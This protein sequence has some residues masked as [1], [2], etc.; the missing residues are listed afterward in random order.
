MPPGPADPLAPFHAPVRRWFLAHVGDPTAAQRH[1]WPAIA[2]GAST[3]IQAPTGSGKTLAAFLWALN[4]LAFGDGGSGCRVVYVSPLKALAVDVERNLRV[5]LAGIREQAA[6]DGVPCAPVSVAVRTGDTPAS[7]RVRFARA[8]ADI[9]ITTPESLFLLLT[10][11]ARDALRTVHTVI[12]D[13]VHALVATKRGAHLALSLERLQALC[14]QTLQRI[15]LS[16]TQRPLDEVARFLGGARARAERRRPPR[17]RASAPLEATRGAD[18]LRAGFADEDASP[19]WRPVTIVNTGE[20]KRL[21]LRIDVPVE[22][23]ARLDAVSRASAPSAPAPAAPPSIWTAVHPRLLALVRSHASTLIFV[24]S[25]RVAERLAA[26]LN[27]LAGEALALAHHGSIAREQ[28]TAIEEALKAGRVR[29]LVATSSLELGIDMGAIDLVVQIEAPPSVASGLQRI[30]RGGHHVDAISEAVIVPKFRADLLA[31]AAVTRALHD[32]HVEESRYPRNPLDVLAQ[33]VV[34]M[35]AMEPWD[36][37]RLFRTIRQAAP[38]A[39]LGRRLFDAVLDM[40]SGR[41]PADDF[42]SLRPR[43]TWDRRAGTVIARDGAR[44]VVVANAGTIPDRGLYGVFLSGAGPGAARVGELDEEMVFESRVGET[45]ILGASTWRIDEITHDR[46]LVSPAPGEPGRMP[47]WKADAPG[48]PVEFG[49]LIGGLVREL[50]DL[51]PPAALARLTSR[52]DLDRQAAENLL[53]YLADQAAATGV[54]PDDR[55]IL[56]ER[57]RDE[58]GNW[59][60]CVLSFLGGAVHAPWA[61]AA[62]ARIRETRGLDV[63]TLWTDD[64][65]V[66]RFPESEE[67]PD[68][69]WLLPSSAD[70]ERLVIAQLGS[71]AYF[72]ARFREAA[73]RALLLPR[74]Q[75]G[76]RTPLWQQRKR[77]TDL[78][79]V[80]ARFGSFP[81]VLEAYRECLR[82][83]FDVPALIDL[84]DQIE[85]RAVRVVTVDTPKPSPFAGAILFGYIANYLYDGDAPAAER[86]AQALTVDQSV[87]R[88]LVGAADLRDVLDADELATLEGELQGLDG[89]RV[90]RSADGLHDLLLWLGDLSDTERAARADGPHTAWARALQRSARAVEVR[91][92]GA[93]RLVAAEYAAQF[94]DALGCALP[95]DVPASLLTPDPAPLDGLVARFA[96][97][98]GPFLTHDV[99]VRYGL[100]PEVVE[101]VLR[102]LAARDAVVEGGFR[103]GGQQR[104]WCSS[105]V[106]RAA[107]HRSWA[108]LRQQAAPV[109]PAALGRLLT[110]WHGIGSGRRGLDALLDAI[111]ILQGAAVPAS[112]LDQ[113]ILPARVADYDPSH[114]DTLAAAGEVTWVG[115]GTLGPRDGLVALYLTDHAARLLPPRPADRRAPA[116]GPGDPREQAVLGALGASGALFFAD[117]H[118][119]TGGG[120]PDDTLQAIW[121]LVWRGLVTNDSFQALRRFVNRAPRGRTA[122]AGG[123]GF[124]S[125]RLA[126]PAGEGR[127]S[128]VPAPAGATT[129]WVASVTEQLLSRYGVLTRNHAAAESIPGGFAA[130][131]P[132]LRALEDAG[133][134]RRG[135]FV[136]GV[137]ASQFAR[138]AAVD[139]L[140]AARHPAA[141]AAAAVLAATDPANPYGATLPWP[142]GDADDPGAAG[143]ARAVGAWVAL[144]DGRLAAFWRTGN[145]AISVWLPPPGPDRARTARALAD[146]L[147]AVA[148][149]GH[150]R[151]GGLLISTING[152]SPGQHALGSHLAGAGF[153]L[154]QRGY[155]VPRTHPT[156][157]GGKE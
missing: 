148:R 43:L 84:L 42:A 96:R 106:L 23:L 39:D 41:Y 81:I 5:P 86:R 15:G 27:D 12:V 104:E 7:D 60:V 71:T 83:H 144:V 112:L 51:P 22:D 87:L 153:V 143:C 113:A 142:P 68:P 19:V 133:R 145:P 26:A 155:A 130:I 56:V 21:S 82:D 99:C 95:A 63:L 72:A 137:A 20:R 103:P 117:L 149:T 77:A 122:P 74:R 40:L 146:G 65:F 35:A 2:G 62:A 93:S 52:H 150:G 25:R 156:R 17:R 88:E 44:R 1:G 46:V 4:R 109:E 129:P 69:A 85:H 105:D 34:A 38:F 80:A 16:A 59:R 120:Y 75:P 36:V 73:G 37:D 91:V 152:G 31:C 49:R 110:A 127:W 89:P 70:V 131:Y 3:L 114:L 57:C 118:G 123:A 124:R 115:A 126:P 78:L 64:G 135:Y 76:R 108:R 97:T 138:P 147:A 14:P 157:P 92:A 116:E 139:L 30:G 13:E 151:T 61:M 29:A 141:D 134:V 98:H 48:R 94:R 50:R 6:A 53:R 11:N 102:R 119:A 111:E 58:L 18:D 66:V 32:G 9:L 8:P 67:P 121:R 45:F 101:P 125:R 28:R 100:T 10:S 107:R 54:V 132:V 55:T 47:F 79:A 24:N 90:A 136:E 154:G 33:Q 140:R 128:L